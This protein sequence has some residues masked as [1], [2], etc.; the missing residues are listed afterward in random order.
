ML[1]AS[2]CTAVSDEQT[3]RKLLTVVGVSGIAG[4]VSANT[5]PGGS[6]EQE[7]AHTSVPQLKTSGNRFVTPDGSAVT[8]RGVSIIDPKRAATT[9]DRGRSS[10]E[11]VA[12]LTDSGRGWYPSVIRIPVQPVDIGDHKHGSAPT[13]PAF[14]TAELEH[15]LTSYLD[16]L[17]AQCAA[18][19]VY[20]II[21]FHRD[22]T[23]WGSLRRDTINKELQL[24]SIMFWET[25]ASRY[26]SLTHVLFEMYNEP[27]EPGM[28]GPTGDTKTRTVWQL[29]VEFIQPIVDTVREHSNA[30]AIVGSPGWSTS[31]E[32]ALIEPIVGGNIAYSYHAYPG[33]DVS[34]AHA[35]N[36]KRTDG[37][38]VERMY[39]S[40]PLFVT[41]FG[42]RDY[43]HPWLGG[44][45]SGF[46]DPFMTWLESDKAINWT[47]WCA[48]VWWDPAMFVQ[49]AETNEWLLRGR[50]AGSD[51]DAGE[52]IKQRLATIAKGGS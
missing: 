16:P 38:G 51:E 4:C 29:F 34:A 48:D 25:V 49:D 43:D 24:E 52:Y 19:N 44:T 21:D 8:L 45:T 6:P 40:Y 37:G 47:A 5:R 28:W 3:R 46:G 10:S 2:H 42:W 17:V 50:D 33:H 13:P 23:Q 31:P 26:G 36:K 20:A 7:N 12:H 41:E 11:V 18:Q 30:I 15:Y 35:W 14:T 9:P 1:I 27:A 39:E 32:G 22:R